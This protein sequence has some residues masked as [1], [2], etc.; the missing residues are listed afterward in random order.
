MKYC[1]KFLR[2]VNPIQDNPFQG[3]SR[4]VVGG[5]GNQKSPLSLKPVKHILND[6]TW[7]TYALPKEDTKNIKIS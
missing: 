4:I 1:N 2:L 3:C 7:H 5:E 6:E